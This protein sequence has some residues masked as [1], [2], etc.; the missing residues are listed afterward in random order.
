LGV[1]SSR[2]FYVTCLWRIAISL[3]IPEDSPSC[4]DSAMRNLVVLFI[5]ALRPVAPRESSVW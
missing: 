2:K 5:N 3:I 4:D 1:L